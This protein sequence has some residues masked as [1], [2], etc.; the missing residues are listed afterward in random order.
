M[1][2]STEKKRRFRLV[3]IGE[4]IAQPT[5]WGFGTPDAQKD[6]RFSFFPSYPAGGQGRN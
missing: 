2:V 1:E 6:H 4:R 5:Y 3:G